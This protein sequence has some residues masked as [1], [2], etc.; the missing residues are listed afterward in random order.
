MKTGPATIYVR[1]RYRARWWKFFIKIAP[2]TVQVNYESGAYYRSETAGRLFRLIDLPIEQQTDLGR[3]T[4]GYGRMKNTEELKAAF[5][6]LN[7][8]N[9]KGRLFLAVEKRVE[10]FIGTG[11]ACDVAKEEIILIAR[12]NTKYLSVMFL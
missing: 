8:T 7:L 2:E 9:I 1:V 3:K 5:N 6:T 4:G 12:L 10:K 11:T